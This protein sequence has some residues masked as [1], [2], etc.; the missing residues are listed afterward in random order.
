M[1]NNTIID[2]LN[3]FPEPQQSPES[4]SLADRVLELSRKCDDL[5]AL[6]DAL[7]KENKRMR[8]VLYTLANQTKDDD[9]TYTEAYWIMIETI[10][11]AIKT[12]DINVD[13]KDS[14]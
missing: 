5:Q 6:D 10:E 4:K 14:E 11:S 1:G 3:Y 13:N 12:G 8:D 9:M 7:H 2:L